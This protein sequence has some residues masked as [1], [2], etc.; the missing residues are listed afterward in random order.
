[1]IEGEKKSM[2]KIMSILEKYKMIEKVDDK[3]TS[4]GQKEEAAVSQVALGK[5]IIV[6]SPPKTVQND[7]KQ[8]KK[9]TQPAM[10]EEYATVKS[11]ERFDKKMTANEIYSI[12]NMENASNNTVF[13]LE[14]LINAL[15]QNL[16][17]DIIKQSILKIID[18]SKIDL[19]N[20]LSDGQQ[21]LDVLSKVNGEF[22]SQT[23]SAILEYK[24]EISKL[25]ALIE[26]YKE[27][28][29]TKEIILEEQ[30]SLIKYETQKLESITDFF[31]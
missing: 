11:K 14:N 19:N 28:I 23:S 15:P 2:K 22:N 9:V 12:Y 6:E 4:V 30:T 25:S 8:V 24:N 3:R 7:T 20:L 26:S 16:P 31:R 29:K 27:Q 5:P 10:N 17:Q 1:M 18:A 13:M 21:R